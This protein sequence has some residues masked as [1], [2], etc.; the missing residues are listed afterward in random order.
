MRGGAVWKLVGLITQRSLVQ[1]QAPLPVIT[2]GYGDAVAPF[3]LDWA[4]FV[5]TVFP[6][7]YKTSIPE[8]KLS[9]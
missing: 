4:R 9:G 6:T 2:R 7:L 8:R 3:L 1:I 5:I